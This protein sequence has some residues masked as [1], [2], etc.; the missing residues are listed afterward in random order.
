MLD[1]NA[2]TASIALNQ[3]LSAR[4][5]VL[6]AVHDTPI[7]LLLRQLPLG[8]LD[9]N[10][11]DYEHL[12][13][14]LVD[15][16]RDPIH[17]DV[18]KQV[19]N[20]ASDTVRRS[21]SH[22]RN[23]AMPHIVR[24]IDIY[25]K[26]MN[27]NVNA[28]L[29][30]DIRRVEQADG[31]KTTAARTYLERWETAAAVTPV[32]AADLGEYSAEEIRNLAKFSEEGG[33][34][35]AI[36]KTLSAN[37]GEGLKKIGEVLRGTL[38][39]RALSPDYALP[40]SI[41][42]MNIQNTPKPGTR[43]TMGNYTAAVTS[44]ANAAGKLA[45]KSLDRLNDERKNQF[46][47]SGPF[48]RDGDTIIIVAEVYNDLLEKG[49]TVDML[50]GNEL[51][52][53]KYNGPQLLIAENQREMEAAYQRDRAIRQQNHQLKRQQLSEKAIL[54]ALREDQ[55][56]VA[57]TGEFILADDTAEK[58]WSRLR[59]FVDSVTSNPVWRHYDPATL[60]AATVCH[61]WYAHT[62]A[63]KI[64]DSMFEIEKKQDAQ[65]KEKM[66]PDQLATLASLQYISEWV[67]SQIGV[68]KTTGGDI[69]ALLSV[70]TV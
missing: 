40:A 1:P 48:S 45:L 51:M 9:P 65:S 22:A 17:N 43:M 47:Y 55:K 58:S 14:V 37:G 56:A 41:V 10:T 3:D 38:D 2:I 68:E 46:L 33:F 13:T 64:I 60:I 62:D 25:A 70:Q 50:F 18:M 57:A 35:E 61:V 30:F 49:F 5:A 12:A 66:P 42:L 23:V 20:L 15:L 27:D 29:P 44:M 53:R 63:H 32:Q 67:C 6:G 52:G 19:V 8:N 28:P 31:L 39:V 4:G 59:S 69:H 7:A 36:D 16:S 54:E 21:L 11:T 24:V 26:M 34:N